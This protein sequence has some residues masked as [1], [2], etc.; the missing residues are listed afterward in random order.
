MLK[1]ELIEKIINNYNK[2]GNNIPIKLIKKCIQDI[3]NQLIFFVK[4]GK[5]IE[6]RDFGSFSTHFRLSRTYKNPKT[7]KIIIIKKKLVPFF[8]PGKKL[9]KRVNLF[10]KINKKL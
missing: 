3:I 1:S 8:K 9:K 2:N 5:K 4:N 7:G 6:I 10:K